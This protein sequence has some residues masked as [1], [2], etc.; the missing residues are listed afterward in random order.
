MS[1]G[2]IVLLCAKDSPRNQWPMA[3]ITKVYP[4]KDK[5]VRKVQVATTSS[6]GKRRFYDRP[7]RELIL[8]VANQS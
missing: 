6:D 2:D 8:L 7:I 4:S 5:L 3:I 1:E